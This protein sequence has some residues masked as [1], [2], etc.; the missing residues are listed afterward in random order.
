MFSYSLVACSLGPP[1]SGQ[2]LY[3]QEDMSPTYTHC[4][5]FDHVCA[6]LLLTAGYPSKLQQLPR[7]SRVS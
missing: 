4:R 3:I 6:Y 7:G 5:L 2:L 1:V